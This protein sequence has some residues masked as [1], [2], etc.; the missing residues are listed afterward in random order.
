MSKSAAA[1]ISLMFAILEIGA[2]VVLW[3]YM[4]EPIRT[5]LGVPLFILGLL[6]LL[7]TPIFFF[8]KSPP[9]EAFFPVTSG[10]TAVIGNDQVRQ[11][12][13]GLHDELD[14]TPHEVLT[15]PGAVR[16]VFDTEDLHDPTACAATRRFRWRTTIAR[17]WFGR[18]AVIH[19]GIDERKGGSWT[20]R[21]AFRGYGRRTLTRSIRNSDG[22]WTTTK[23]DKTTEISRALT[24]ARKK[25]KV[26][27]AMDAAGVVALISAIGTIVAVVATLF[28]PS[29]A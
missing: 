6:T 11:M 9:D 27:I 26:K 5:C 29:A 3:L 4:Q 25:A 28:L 13:E 2:G 12:A 24:A 21:R 22:T 20:E 10:G 17:F 1:V 18:Y 19:E 23:I 16:V 15:A 14:S 8:Q 7:A